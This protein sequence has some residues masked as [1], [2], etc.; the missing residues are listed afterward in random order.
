[1]ASATAAA[2]R[3]LVIGP[4]PLFPLASHPAFVGF[5][6]LL[7]CAVAGVLAGG[8]SF[9]LTQAVYAA[10]DAFKRLPFHWMWWPLLGGLAI[11]LGG[12]IAP[13]ALGVGYDVIGDLLADRFAI[14][15]IAVLVTVK[16]LIWS[17]SL[18]SGTSVGVLAPLLMVGG[19]V[20]ALEDHGFPAAGTGFWPLVGMGAILGGTMRSP[21]TGIVFAVELTHDLNMV[22]PLAVAVVVAHG[23]TVLVL[24]RSILTE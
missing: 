11:G 4:G 7:G 14:S 8:L 21:L 5:D 17:I 19:A 23:F 18:G 3:H 22:V 16:A 10:E 24:R 12:L 1:L 2:A 15:A 9:G 20:G 13:R 6:V